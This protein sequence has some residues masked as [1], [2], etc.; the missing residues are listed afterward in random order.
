MNNTEVIEK[1]IKSSVFDNELSAKDVSP[2]IDSKDEMFVKGAEEHYFETGLSALKNI[3]A[4]LRGMGKDPKQ[5]KH[6]LD[7]P[8]GYGRVMRFTKAYFPNAEFYGSEIEQRYLD[9]CATTF[10]AKVFLSKDKFEEIQISQ[11]FDIIWV[12]SLFTHL[13]SSRFKKL[14]HFLTSLLKDDGV[15]IFTTHGRYCYGKVQLGS[16]R[17]YLIDTG[18]RLTGYGY[19]HQFG[20]KKYGDSLTSPKWLTKFISDETDTRVVYWAEQG[21]QNWQDVFAVTPHR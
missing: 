16:K 2:T 14:Y 6:V 21:W 11:K 1:V 3:S 18:Y 7:F 13:T 19:C 20:T 12:G 17:R 8:C 9:F 15:L 10:E 5:I 4:V